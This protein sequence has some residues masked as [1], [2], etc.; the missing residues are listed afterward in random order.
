MKA[1]HA[2]FII[3]ATIT[4]LLIMVPISNGYSDNM[5][6]WTFSSPTVPVKLSKLVG[7]IIKSLRNLSIIVTVLVITILGFK[8]MVGSVE[9]KSDYKKDFPNII[10][11]VTVIAG[12]FSIIS[13]MFSIAEQIV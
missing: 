4:L 2:A 9:Q 1:K 3:L 6:D 13:M 8:Y 5:L 12:V 7:I 10:I 11:G